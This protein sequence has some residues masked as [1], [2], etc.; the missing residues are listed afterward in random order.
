M[1]DAWRCRWCA[2]RA[3]RFT[4]RSIMS[5]STNLMAHEDS[6]AVQHE[7][8]SAPQGTLQRGLLILDVLIKTTHPMT[9][10]SI[11]A[12]VKLDLSTTLRLLRSLE[13]MKRVMRVGDGKQ[14]LASPSALR[15]LHLKHPLEELRRQADP[16]VRTLASKIGETV[17]L[18]AY[19]GGE[20]LV[21]DVF[22]APDSLSPYYSTW[23]LGPYHASAPGKAYLLA[24]PQERRSALL[25][26]EPFPALTPQTITSAKALQAQLEASEERGYVSIR[27]EY[28]EGVSA[29]AANFQAWDGRVVGCLAITG[30]TASF[31]DERVEQIAAELLACTRLMPLQ[32]PSLQQLLSFAVR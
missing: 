20:R 25:G 12:E 16:L 21:V 17:V 7:S 8:K 15:P 19:V 32:V 23:L 10:A 6:G 11:A 14:Y 24:M 3:T 27:D 2:M 9:L 31:T 13:E 29:L 26:P 5:I 22:Q 1:Q 4:L 30:F 28:Y 18:I